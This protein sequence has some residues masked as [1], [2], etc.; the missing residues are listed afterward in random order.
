MEIRWKKCSINV[1]S[2]LLSFLYTSNF[3]SES[4][5]PN[6][7]FIFPVITSL[8]LINYNVKV[9]HLAHIGWYFQHL[10]VAV[11]TCHKIDVMSSSNFQDLSWPIYW[12]TSTCQSEGLRSNQ[13]ETSDFWIRVRRA[14]PNSLNE[15]QL[16]WKPNLIGWWKFSYFVG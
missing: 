8:L 15:D 6:S 9:I 12:R 7:G 11:A 16:L 4:F 1:Y 13:L 14:W 3:S 2:F 5:I 10:A